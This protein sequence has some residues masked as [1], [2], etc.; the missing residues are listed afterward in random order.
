MTVDEFI[1]DYSLRRAREIQADMLAA[2]SRRP[3]EWTFEEVT[4]RTTVS[5][6]GCPFR[7][8]SEGMVLWL[9]ALLLFIAADDDESRYGFSDGDQV[10]IGCRAIGEQLGGNFWIVNPSGCPQVLVRWLLKLM[11][12]DEDFE[13]AGVIISTIEESLYQKFESQEIQPDLY[14]DCWKG[15]LQCNEYL[16]EFFAKTGR[17][18]DSTEAAMVKLRVALDDCI[19]QIEELGME[20]AFAVEADIFEHIIKLI[21]VIEQKGREDVTHRLYEFARDYYRAT[22]RDVLAEKFTA[23]LAGR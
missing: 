1:D 17:F 7:L 15:V 5:F 6:D 21:P 11:D 13:G 3:K 23:K 2:S 18:T 16:L 19:S 14:W 9:R 20:N 22:R 8:K 4:G 10:L 12:D